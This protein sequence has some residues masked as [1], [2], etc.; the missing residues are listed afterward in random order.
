MTDTDREHHMQWQ[1]KVWNGTTE[2]LLFFGTTLKH[3]RLHVSV[4]L[5][6]NRPQQFGNSAAE[7]PGSTQFTYFYSG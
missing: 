6:E 7:H 3:L 2:A 5:T 4:W 1:T